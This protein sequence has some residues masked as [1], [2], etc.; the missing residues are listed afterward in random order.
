V[1]ETLRPLVENATPEQILNLRIC[2]PAM[3]SGAFLVPAVHQL[4][5]A[6]GEALARA[7]EDIDHKLDDTERAAYRR[8]I[9]E[10]CIYGVD[11]NPMAVDLAKVSLWLAAAAAGKPL[12]FLD[13]HLRGGNSVIGASIATWEGVPQPAQNNRDSE[14]V[15]EYQE[16]LFELDEPDLRTLINVRRALAEAP[17]EDRLQVRAKE[18]R[19]SR[20]IEGDDFTRL[21][22]LGNWWVAPF[23]LP[24]FARNA[25][26][27]RQGRHQVAHGHPPMHQGIA[28]LRH[29]VE[30]Y[31]GEEIR[32]FHWEIEFPEVFFDSNG[33]RR[34][35]AGFDAIIGNPPWENVVFRD[36]EFYGR[37]DPS[38]AL[39]KGK[40]EKRQRRSI[41]DQRADVTNALSR[42]DN[43]LSG[44]K[45]FIKHSGLFEMLYEH[46]IAF[47]YYRLFLERELA[48]LAI[49]GRIG[50]TIDAGVVAGASTAAHRRE[51]IS[52]CTVERFVLCDNANKI[53]PIDS[54][55]QFLLLVA[56]KGG[57][58]DPLPFTSNVSRLEHL[59]D[60]EGRTLPISRA[61]LQSL[62]PENLA[63]P[64]IRDPALLD[65]LNVI[66]ADRP[67]L[68][69]YMPVGGWQIDWGREINIDDDSAYFIE[70]G[71]GAPLLE[72]KHLHQFVHDF[73]KPTYRLKQPEGEL[74]LLNRAV[75][76]AKLKGDV[77]AKERRRGEL[78]LQGADLR[79]GGL[80][81]PFDQYRAGLR[82]VA[83][84]TNE[85]TLIAAVV[86]PGTSFTESV[87]WFYRSAWDFERHGYR[88]LLPARAMV[89]VVALMNSMVLDFVVRR[90]AASHV[91]KTIMSTI[92]IVDVLLNQGPGAEI[93]GLLRS[94]LRGSL[95][96][97]FGTD[98]GACEAGATRR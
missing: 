64:D 89:Y 76:R 5:E 62:D 81:S 43:K 63:V 92:P 41:L 1:V 15:H 86:P 39:L 58:T 19:F 46:G 23:F 6:Y 34:T 95:T 61:T 71:N 97:A 13:A 32:P 28:S 69:Q 56:Q 53:F 87:H 66:C 70:G 68:L 82:Q 22:A 77:R 40:E 52:R 91:T 67:F 80:E 55:E 94:R 7:G 35:D 90:R 2:D 10:R 9:V 93:A 38:Y 11:L 98:V 26:E 14:A 4:T 3:G 51:L 8:L 12:S 65:V 83:S 21:H 18:K 50:V 16:S 49:N 57:S 96:C 25:N 37:F 88:T 73:A 20:L 33:I 72:G 45:R 85:R 30:S 75:K 42:D 47:N 54:R 31:I 48:L 27:W 84:A 44:I 29:R 74:Y 59:L 24:E 60:M 36:K 78:F 79:R 17:S